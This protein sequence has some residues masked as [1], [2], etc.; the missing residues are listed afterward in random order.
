MLKQPRISGFQSYL[1]QIPKK[2][3]E[4]QNRTGTKTKQ[5]LQSPFGFFYIS[6]SED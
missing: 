1:N 6:H 4:K 3:E 5:N 2:S